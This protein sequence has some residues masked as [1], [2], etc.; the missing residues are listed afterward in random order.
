MAGI[1]WVRCLVLVLLMG[2][3][4]FGVDAW[5]YVKGWEN[6]L[7]S[8]LVGCGVTVWLH[9]AYQYIEGKI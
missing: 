5:V 7:D 4:F 2:V 8:I 3:L 6:V 9:V 1:L